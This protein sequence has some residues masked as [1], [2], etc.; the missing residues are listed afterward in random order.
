MVVEPHAVQE[1]MPIW[2]G[3]RS[4]RS[5]RRAVELGDGWA[6]FGLAPPEIGA[7]VERARA[8]PAW[9]AREQPLD[10]VLQSQRAF[11]PQG[12]PEATRAEVAA[13]VDAGATTLALRFVHHSA[14]HYIEQM[15]A[16][17]E[18]MAVDRLTD[19]GAAQGRWRSHWPGTTIS[20]GA[21]SIGVRRPSAQRST[22]TGASSAATSTGGSSR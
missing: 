9:A 19:G 7:L 4:G 8:T 13:L 5:L 10:L 6:P 22:S 3:G 21:A 16:M 11:D 14:E 20:N 15:A 2:V 1:H 12:K 18:L 17:V